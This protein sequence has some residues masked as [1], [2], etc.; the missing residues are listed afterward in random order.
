MSDQLEVE[1][2][3]SLGKAE[4]G[5]LL[6]CVEGES[7]HYGTSLI[8]DIFAP[9]QLY[10][11]PGRGEPKIKASQC[12]TKYK[13]RDSAAAQRESG[14]Q[15]VATQVSHRHIIVD[16]SHICVSEKEMYR[17]RSR[18][19]ARHQRGCLLLTFCN[20]AQRCPGQAWMALVASPSI[21]H[22]L[23]FIVRSWR[24]GSLLRRIWCALHAGGE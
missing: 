23:W 20:T 3:K 9:A 2:C 6:C 14:P 10:D 19:C 1:N 8:T 11:S 5:P 24:E 17:C 13:W 22:E 18:A 21:H 15:I 4:L 16:I 7:A 12:F